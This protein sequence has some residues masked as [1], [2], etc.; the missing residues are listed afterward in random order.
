MYELIKSDFGSYLFIAIFSGICFAWGGVYGI[1]V[2]TKKIEN[3]VLKRILR[4]SVSV[5]CVGFW[6]WFFVYKNLYPIALAKYE[7]EHN[8][9]EEQV[10]TVESVEMYDKGRFIMTIDGVKYTFLNDSASLTSIKNEKGIGNSVRFR[11]GKKSKVIFDISHQKPDY[12]TSHGLVN[13]TIIRDIITPVTTTPEILR[14]SEKTYTR[15]G[16]RGTV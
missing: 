13:K 4:V 1:I 7:Y 2:N 16:L 6:L 9:I 8:C 3:I 11:Y 12:D 10:G 5:V 15:P 14:T